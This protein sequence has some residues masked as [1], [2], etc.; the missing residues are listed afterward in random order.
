MSMFW[1]LDI[2]KIEKWKMIW[3]NLRYMEGDNLF[4]YVI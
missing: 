2:D 4:M 3:M 1:F